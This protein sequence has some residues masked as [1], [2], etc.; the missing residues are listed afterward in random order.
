M[1]VREEVIR[2]LMFG[3]GIMGV[4]WI[5]AVSELWEIFQARRGKE[6]APE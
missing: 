3:L 6:G 2:L 4:V 1:A 5:L